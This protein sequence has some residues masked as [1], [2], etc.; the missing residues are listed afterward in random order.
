MH[1]CIYVILYMYQGVGWDTVMHAYRDGSIWELCNIQQTIINK[2]MKISSNYHFL[3]DG[4]YSS[5]AFAMVLYHHK[6]LRIRGTK[7]LCNSKFNSC[8]CG[9]GI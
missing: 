9:T 7:I 8:Y 5:K 6:G 1:L 4:Y 2:E 3:R